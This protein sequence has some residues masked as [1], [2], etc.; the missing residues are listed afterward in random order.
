MSG[1]LSADQLGSLRSLLLEQRARLLERGGIEITEDNDAEPMDLQEKAADEVAR[2]DRLALTDI[3]RQRLFE[4]N[5]ALARMADGSYG[6]CEESG[7][8]IPFGRL[9]AEPTTRYTVEAQ[10]LVEAEASREKAVRRDPND[11]GY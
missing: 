1:H 11:T 7:D 9:Q 3:D 4:V 10:E 5:A 6:E 8:P 2:R